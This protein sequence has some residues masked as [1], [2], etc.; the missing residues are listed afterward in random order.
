MAERAKHSLDYARRVREADETAVLAVL[1]AEP[2]RT[3][4][5]P[6]VWARLPEFTRD[7]LESALTRLVTQGKVQQ[8]TGNQSNRRSWRLARPQE[9]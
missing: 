9:G 4:E 7:R 5:R 1:A 6:D 2:D 3:F 8:G